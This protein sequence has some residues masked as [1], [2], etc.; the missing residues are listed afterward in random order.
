MLKWYFESNC[1]NIL[2]QLFFLTILHADAY[3]YASL[4]TLISINKHDKHMVFYISE[5]ELQTFNFLSICWQFW[6][7][8]LIWKNV[9]IW[10]WNFAEVLHDHIPF[11]IYILTPLWSTCKY[12]IY[13]KFWNYYFNGNAIFTTIF[14]KFNLE[15]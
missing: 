5:F 3:Y 10:Q 9:L 2:L 8:K 6:F 13:L 4:N 1:R 7:R 15:F 12:S 14:F 11:K